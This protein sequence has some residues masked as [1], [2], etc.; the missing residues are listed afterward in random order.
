MLF[1]MNG[2]SKIPLNEIIWHVVPFLGVLLVAL[3]ILT[4]FADLILYLPRY[5][6]YQGPL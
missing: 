4:A 6:G 1:V 5:F 3:L 2:T